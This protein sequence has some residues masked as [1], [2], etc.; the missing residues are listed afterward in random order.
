MDFMIKKAFEG[1][2][3]TLKGLATS[4]AR[5]VLGITHPIATDFSL[6]RLVL[7]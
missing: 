2:Y 3:P 7:F 4:P 5:G 1:V 6:V